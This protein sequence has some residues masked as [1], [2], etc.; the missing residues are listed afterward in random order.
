MNSWK[1]TAD[2]Y[3]TARNTNS[4]HYSKIQIAHPSSEVAE[5]FSVGIVVTLFGSIMQ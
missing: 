4:S 2:C 5:S 3:K 1:A